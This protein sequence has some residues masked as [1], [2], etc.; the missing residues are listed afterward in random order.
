MGY[1]LPKL[2]TLD[3]GNFLNERAIEV[4]LDPQLKHLPSG[5][6]FVPGVGVN[7]KVTANSLQR[8]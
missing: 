7:R 5:R 1:N 4:R 8:E 6:R 2:E 3:L